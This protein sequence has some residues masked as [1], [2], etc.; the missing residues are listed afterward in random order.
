MG[1]GYTF[2][3]LWGFRGQ[4]WNSLS[5]VA[6]YRQIVV[7]YINYSASNSFTHRTQVHPGILYLYELGIQLVCKYAARRFLLAYNMK[8]AITLKLK[9]NYCTL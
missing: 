9:F 7:V 6:A 3:G 2:R 8:D 4:C 5:V 1:T